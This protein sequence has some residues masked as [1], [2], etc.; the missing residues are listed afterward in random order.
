MSAIRNILLN[1][2]YRPHTVEELRELGV[3]ADVLATL[4]TDASYGVAFF[5]KRRVIGTARGCR[6]YRRMPRREWVAVPIADARIPLEW[7]EGARDAIANNP[8]PAFGGGGRVHE[9]SGGVLLCG[10]CGRAMTTSSSTAGGK[11]KC[12]YYGC[13]A[14]RPRDRAARRCDNREMHRAERLEEEVVGFVDRELL[15]DPARL[16]AHMDA[17]IEREVAALGSPAGT[18]AAWAERLAEVARRRE[19]LLD[20]AERGLVTEGDLAERLPR[21]DGEWRTAEEALTRSKEA[22]S[23]I[24]EMERAKRAVLEMFGSGL[25]GGVYWFPPRLRRQVYGLLGL[26]VEIFP[27]RTLRIE[28]EFDANLMRLTPEVEEY[29][30]GMREI[31]ERLQRTGR[32]DGVTTQEMVDR[33]EL[34]L[35]AL[36]DG[37]CA[38][39]ATSG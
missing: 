31:D 22:G 8:R 15:T 2:A 21:L 37:L 14:S 19:R 11:K 23:R 9:L 24:A 16:E 30:A 32:G 38:S 29:V 5:G 36:K 7:V 39:A 17:A 27:D 35:A 1:D 18:E 3:S 34:E 20:L 25:M 13:P 33:I 26:R 10:E 12:W 4:E 6:T 28:G